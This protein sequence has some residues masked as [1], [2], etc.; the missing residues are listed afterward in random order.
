MTENGLSK[1][2][3]YGSDDDILDMLSKKRKE[4]MSVR[5]AWETK[6]GINGKEGQSEIGIKDF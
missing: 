2:V 6:V 4:T 5:F 3:E 1:F